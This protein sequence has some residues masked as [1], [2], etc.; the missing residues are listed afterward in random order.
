MTPA[1]AGR[2]ALVT[3]A[4]RG[5]GKGIALG[6]AEAGAEVWVT[7]RTLSV[8]RGT[9]EG[10]ASSPQ[11]G[12]LEETVEEIITAGGRAVAVP[13]DLVDDGQVERLFA[14]LAAERP[15]LDVLVNSAWGGYEEMVEGGEFTW[16]KPFWEQSLRRWDAMF[17]AGLRASF[18]CSRLAA[19]RMVAQ[20]SGLIVNV[21]FWAARK[22]LGN[23][24]YGAAKCATDRLTEDMARDL[25]GTGVVAVALYPGLV[26]TEK[27]LAAS[28]F[29]D[30]ANSES[31]QFSGRAIAYLA[32]DPRAGTRSG[33]VVV[34]AQL[35]IEYGFTDVD[36]RQPLPLTL[37]TS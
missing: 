31:P 14:R 4:S 28:A 5:V 13:C 22:Y 33:K 35:A 20:G 10:A 18:A 36:G 11:E 34:A 27:V 3:G 24:I 19:R 9:A 8:T 16:T 7:A 2:T 21:S 29:L 26:R 25:A 6:L 1:L 12:S 15:A 23:A 37:A 30:L 17:D 32:A